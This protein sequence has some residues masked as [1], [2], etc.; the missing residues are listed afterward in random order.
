M[1][2]SFVISRK[3]FLL[4]SVTGIV[5]SDRRIITTYGNYVKNI[6]VDHEIWI[7]REDNGKDYVIKFRE[8][9]PLMDGLKL[10]AVSINYKQSRY[11]VFL[12]NES[13]C[14]S[15]QIINNYMFMEIFFGKFFGRFAMIVFPLILFFALLALG[16]HIKW[17]LLG[18]IA[19]FIL[20]WTIIII[21]RNRQSK[22][23]K[24]AL[25][26]FLKDLGIQP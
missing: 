8:N 20:L 21:K 13:S 1:E 6:I 26:R 25:S 4:S 11:W 23:Y 19:L 10:T 17:A 5:K 24:E 18:L 12:R 22:L 15:H 9:I 16:L 7:E 14:T 2:Q 3:Q